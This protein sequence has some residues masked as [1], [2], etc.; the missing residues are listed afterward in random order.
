VIYL[1]H[2]ATTPVAPEVLEAMMPYLTCN[3]GNPSST[4]KFGAKLKGVLELARE[5]V[6]E[7]IGAHAREI[8]FTSCAT[9]SNN[10][11]I[12]A[13][14]RATGKRHIVTSVVEHSSVLN[15]CKAL[16]VDGRKKAQRDTKTEPLV[17]TDHRAASSPETSSARPAVTP[18]R[19]TYLPV[20]RDGL[21]NLADLEKAITD[22]TAVVSLMWANNET[23]VLFPVKEIA[24]ICQ[25]RGVLFHCDAVQAAGKIEIDVRKVPADYL[26]LTGHKFGAPKGIGALYV[27]RKAPFVPLIQG[28]HQEGNRRGGTE[29]VPLIVGMGK[30]A[31]L[32]RKKPPA[33]DKKVRP[34]RDALEEGILRSIPNTELNGH[35]T[36]R[37]ANTTNITFRAFTA[38]Q[39]AKRERT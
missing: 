13:A 35:R 34:L 32:A 25:A 9:E 19:V 28:G 8:I 6:A 24:E 10:A 11:A 29:S 15:Y 39:Q 37:L 26:S 5:Q 1:D 23:G 17:V 21:L 14:L 12:H 7:L 4:Y 18:Y 31:E 33:Y 3:W 27:R 16:E 2:N 36:Q 20:D 30:A 38:S 22:E